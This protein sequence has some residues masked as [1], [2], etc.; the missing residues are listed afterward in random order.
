MKKVNINFN[1]ADALTLSPKEDTLYNIRYDGSKP[2]QKSLV[3]SLT[4]PNVSC[5]VYFGYKA[6]LG[7]I[8]DLVTTVVHKAPYTTSDTEIEGVLYDGGI[9]NYQGKVIVEKTA[10]GSVS[11][12]EDRVLVVGEGTHNHAEP[13]MQIETNDVTASHAS[14]TGRVDENQLYYLQSRGLSRDE[15]QDLLVDAFLTPLGV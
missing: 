14:T 5:T 10:R 6:S 13:V 15:S 2:G 8:I 12:L 7:T 4:I 1:S 11:R 9:S 3:V